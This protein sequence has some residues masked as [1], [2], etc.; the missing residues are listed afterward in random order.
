MEA[1]PAVP[2][3]PATASFRE[4]V[5]VLDR[6]AFG[7]VFVLG[8]GRRRTYCRA[9]VSF[10][11]VAADEADRRAVGNGHIDVPE[12][13]VVAAGIQRARSSALT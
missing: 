6:H 4:A 7:A 3:I 1:L 8:D 13:V 11:C 12:N 2:M 9:N 5:T 10:E